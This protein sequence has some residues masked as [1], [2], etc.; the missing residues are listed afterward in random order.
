MNSL[1]WLPDLPDALVTTLDRE[2]SAL[3]KVKRRSGVRY[4]QDATSAVVTSGPMRVMVIPLAHTRQSRFPSFGRQ[5]RCN[6]S[7]RLVDFYRLMQC[8]LSN[9]EL[10][11]MDYLPESLW[12]VRLW[13]QI[14]SAR[15]II[16]VLVQEV[17]QHCT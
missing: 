17:C 6:Q 3:E 10:G 16:D 2:Q 12:F 1:L 15:F 7:V 11:A 13:S 8:L 4:N 14:H 9:D 5:L